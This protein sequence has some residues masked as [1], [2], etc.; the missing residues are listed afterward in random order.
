MSRI[1]S[2][3][4]KAS[5]AIGALVLVMCV[6]LAFVA[7]NRSSSAVMEEVEQALKMQAEEASIYVESRFQTE[8]GILEAI[9]ERPEVK[10][11]R[12][13]QRPSIQAEVERLPQVLALG[14]IDNYGV[15]RYTDGTSDNLAGQDYVTRALAGEAVV[16]DP[17]FSEIDNSLVLMYAVP[18]IDFDEIKGAL[19]AR[20]DASILRDMADRLGFG[21]G[22]WGYIFHRNG[23]IFAHPNQE[24]VLEQVNIFDE[25]GELANLGKAVR[26]LGDNTGVISFALD[27]VA[28]ISALAPIPST[29][30]IVGIG[31][32]EDDVLVNVNQLRTFL[33][34]ISAGFILLGVIVAFLI[35]RNIANPLQ[36]VQAVLGAVADGDLTKTTTVRSND[37]IGKLAEALNTTVANLKEVIGRV[38]NVTSE[39]AGT[40]QQMAAASEEVSASIEEV[41]STTNRFS[42]SLDVMSANARKMGATAQDISNQALQG[43]GAI[44]DIVKQMNGL[45]DNTQDMSSE[46]SNLGTLSDEIG[47]IVEVISAIAD[48]TNLLALNAAIEAARAGEH[49]RGFAVVAD[50]VRKLAEQSAKA[51]TEITVLI[52]QIQGGISSTVNRMEGSAE[53]TVQALGS[54]QKSGQLLRGILG[55]VDGIVDQVQEM[56]A[57][58][59]DA[60][61]GGREIASA[62]EEQAASIQQVAHSAQDLTNMG[63]ELQELVQHFTLDEE[64]V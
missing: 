61:G 30:W 55:A 13:A 48:Q 38:S 44:A 63:L 36:E 26:E 49:G 52:S 41:A 29:D 10:A 32:L 7:Y 28:H 53:Q 57:G 25:T 58:I 43:E 37:E 42:S 33:V 21:E 9:A 3:A 39:L 46:V 31:A 5:L 2:V 35:A 45:R 24:Y 20:Q 14:L 1:N 40:S 8:F 64:K 56:S 19:L 60:N 11:M 15:A 59:E 6:G 34:L 27:N 51:A 16:T 23:T 18:V 22:G 4:A 54:V 47:N 12:E 17:V 62:T 50:E